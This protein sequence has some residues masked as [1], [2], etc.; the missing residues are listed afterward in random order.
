MR[1]STYYSQIDALKGIA[2]FLVVLGHSIILY[3]VN[4]HEN[5]FCEALYQWLWHIQLTIIFVKR[6][7]ARNK[8]NDSRIHIRNKQSPNHYFV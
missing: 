2:I 5:I 1:E 6:L 7:S 4:L 8:Q 3:P